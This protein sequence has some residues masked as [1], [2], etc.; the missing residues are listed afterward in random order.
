MRRCL[1]TLLLLVAV[2]SPARAD[3]ECACLDGLNQPV[4][5]S[6]TDARPSCP[7]V[8]CTIAP[9]AVSEEEDVEP[10]LPPPRRVCRD[11]MEWDPIFREYERVRVCR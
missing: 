1:L 10:E 8:V 7:D 9:P 6:D 4:C 11:E 3:C 5:S 2:T